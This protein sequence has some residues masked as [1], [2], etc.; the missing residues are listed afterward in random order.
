MLMLHKNAPRFDKRSLFTKVG[1]W[2]KRVDLI[3]ISFF[4]KNRSYG[5]FGSRLR[6]TVFAA[7]FSNAVDF[8]KQRSALIPSLSQSFPWWEGIRLWAWHMNLFAWYC[9]HHRLKAQ[10]GSCSVPE[11]VC[12]GLNGPILLCCVSRIDRVIWSGSDSLFQACAEK[13]SIISSSFP[14]EMLKTQWSVDLP[15][16]PWTHEV[17]R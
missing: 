12:V 11:S 5:C 16:S 3:K 10:D 6:L 4:K 1:G 2:F 14:A 8:Q 17:L 7:N 9:E 13:S 15:P